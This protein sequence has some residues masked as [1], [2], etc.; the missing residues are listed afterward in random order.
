MEYLT[1]NNGVSMPLIGF[2]T[3]MLGGEACKNAV[4]AAIQSGYRMIDTAEAY[5]NEKA[6]GEGIRQS[7]M[8]RRELFLVTKVNF[9]SYENAEQSVM[10][11]LQDLQTDYLDLL[12]SIGPLP[13][14][15]RRGGH[16]KS[17]MPAEA[18]GPSASPT[19]GRTGCWI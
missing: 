9:K 3:F 11:S 13:T 4:A 16:W 1:L 19:S 6:V 17:C 7:G 12:L 10:R 15:M 5:G 14:T 18:S 2:G 8:D